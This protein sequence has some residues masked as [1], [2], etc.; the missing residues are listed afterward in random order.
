MHI[1]S[2]RKQDRRVR[3]EGANNGGRTKEEGE[4]AKEKKEKERKALLLSLSPLK[5][6]ISLTW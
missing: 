1:I 3:Q 6:R 5:S 2:Y 4:N